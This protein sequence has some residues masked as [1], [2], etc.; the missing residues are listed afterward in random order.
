[1]DQKQIVNQILILSAQCNFLL[2]GSESTSICL[3]LFQSAESSEEH[4]KDS[5]LMQRI[6]SISYNMGTLLSKSQQFDAAVDFFRKSLEVAISSLSS[7]EIIVSRLR[8]LCKCLTL[9]HRKK[10]R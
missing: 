3:D 2:N 1:M 5:K 6:S 10:E 7:P 4:I 9:T 8:A